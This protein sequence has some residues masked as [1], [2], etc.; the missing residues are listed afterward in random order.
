[1]SRQWGA[2]NAKYALP[3]EGLPRVLYTTFARAAASVTAPDGV[4]AVLGNHDNWHGGKLCVD[5]FQSFGIKTLQNEE[6]VIQ[7]G[8]AA[9][10]LIGVDDY[11]TG[12]PSFPESKL[13]Q[14][15]ATYG[16]RARFGST[17]Q[18]S[19]VSLLLAHNPD[20]VGDLFRFTD[21]SVDIAL[22]GHTHGGQIKIPGT[23][24]TPFCNVQNRRFLEGLQA[25]SKG[26][27]YTSRGLGV[28]EIPIRISC[29]PETCI[30]TLSS[31]GVD[32]P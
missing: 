23:P 5:I 10:V 18:K 16:S 27:V 29:R 30:F 4:F 6:H 24:Y 1:V 28:V 20:Y 3:Y 12:M 17:S 2:R 32:T 9:L 7:R 26:T 19:V 15:V 31:S 8:D 13:N 25:T 22:C 11:L 14:I 21:R